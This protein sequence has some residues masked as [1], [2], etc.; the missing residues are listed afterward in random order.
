MKNVGLSL[1][2]VALCSLYGAQNVTLDAVSIEEEKNVETLT[3]GSENTKI[4]LQNEA[5]SVAT[6]D[7]ALKK[8]FFVTD[9]KSGDYSSEP[10]IRGRG[11]KGVPLYLEG[12]RVNAAHPDSTN[13]FNMIDVEA[14]E[15]YRGASGVSVG[16]GAMS[17]GIV[18]RYKKPLFSTSNEFENE[19]FITAK[20]SM[21]STSGYTT[22]L[23]T[24]LYNQYINLSLSGGLS[25]YA[26]YENANGDEVLHSESDTSHYNIATALKT[27]DDSYIYARFSKDKASSGDPLSRYQNGGVWFYT[28]RPND[29]AKTYFVGFKKEKWNG[30]RDIDIQF[31]KNEI[32]YDMNTK[33]EASIPYATEL[34]RES[35]TKGVNLSANKILN[36]NHFLSFATTYSKMEIDNGV[37]KWNGGTNSWNPWTNAFGIKGGD[38]ENFGFKISDDM[39]Y[40]KAFYNIGLSYENVKRDVKSNVNTTALT[41]LVPAAL[42]AQ[43][44]QIDTNERENLFSISA[45]AGYELSKA[46]IPYIKFSNSQR[47]PYF[48]EAY[49]NNPS[50]GTLIP[51]QTLENE[52]VW[53]FDVGFDGKYNSFYY[54]SALYYQR[55]SDYI[56][57]VKT[58]YMTTAATPLAIKQYVN[59]DKATIYGA[60][61]MGGYGFGNDMF[62]EASYLYTYGQNEDDDTPLAFIA[63][64]K[65]ILSIAQKKSKGLSWSVEEVFV[66][67]QDRISSVNGE[68]KT[69]G[70][71]LTNA[72]VSYGFSQVGFLKNA[73]LSLDLNNIFDKK[74][75]EHL[76]KV[77]ATAWYLPDSPGVNGTLS[78]KATF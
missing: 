28:D 21:F 53:G 41:G 39:S 67:K 54:T 5:V 19:S 22:T 76:D 35:E 50:N 25:D 61:L 47:T 70:Y 6:I 1:I 60:E 73:T 43:V 69:S 20:S 17:G 64:Q 29:E 62:I 11:T 15:V 23:G 75:R 78:F 30:L 3:L 68:I 33:K 63:P 71:A 18:V 51:N 34:F 66:D 72:S 7:E 36:E 26:N 4:L 58:G 42:L 38:I 57:L 49:G 52:K 24:T 31:F 77:S 12:M 56:E 37:R 8:Q 40:G 65:F 55:Y 59:L 46:F 48:N 13:L 32:H 45:K 74:Y 14:V 9:I 10:Y 16:M 27:G 2:T 44:Q